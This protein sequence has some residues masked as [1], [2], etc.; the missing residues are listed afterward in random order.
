[1]SVERCGECGF[2]SDDWS[3]ASA[4]AAIQR[5]PLQWT[6]AVAGLTPSDQLR[7]PVHQMWSIAE[8]ADHV[9]EVLFGMRF[10]L[11]TAISQPGTDLGES[12]PQQFASQP[13]QID[14]EAALDGIDHEAR[15]LSQQLS[16]LSSHDW[17]LT[18]RFDETSVDAHW[19]ARHIVH[20]ATHHLLDVDRV[21]SAL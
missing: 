10:L 20:D 8:Y 19:I 4:I 7:R 14:V 3:D 21:R 6:T 13:R 15:S 18:V 16:G 5:L 12:P 2:D 17:F 11:D 9:R 1:M